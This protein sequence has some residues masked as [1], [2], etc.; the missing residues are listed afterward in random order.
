MEGIAYH[1]TLQCACGADVFRAWMEFKWSCCC[2]LSLSPAL[3]L[4]IFFTHNHARFPVPVHYCLLTDSG[5]RKIL[6]LH[7]SEEG[8]IFLFLFAASE[9]S[10]IAHNRPEYLAFAAWIFTF[11]R[12]SLL[13][14]FAHAHIDESLPEF[15]FCFAIVCWCE[16]AW[17]LCSSICCF[18]SMSCLAHLALWTNFM[19]KKQAKT[20][21]DVT[22]P[23][24]QNDKTSLWNTLPST[25]ML[26]PHQALTHQEFSFQR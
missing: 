7:E 14:R 18:V 19:N 20:R 4:T 11:A 5:E 17:A 9:P 12:F 25:A 15:R 16:V 13:R 3:R 1:N 26:P 24:T 22:C 6:V 10:R 2:A 8:K 23:N 21:D